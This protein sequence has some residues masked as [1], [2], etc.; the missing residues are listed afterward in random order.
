MKYLLLGLLTF[1]VMYIFDYLQFRE[2]RLKVLAG[3]FGFGGF[4]VAIIQLAKLGHFYE[5]TSSFF[6]LIVAVFFMLLLIW[7]VFIE[8]SFAPTYMKKQ[9]KQLL[10]STGTYALTRHPG[11]VWLF[12]TLLGLS[13]W[14]SSY[15]LLLGVFIFTISNIV[16]VIFQEK[17]FEKMIP[18]YKIYQKEVP[19]LIPNRSS[20]KKLLVALRRRIT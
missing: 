13:L 1:P 6:G 18:G 4:G 12:F 10:V 20:I 11:V 15:Y 17:L 2:S 7:S 5:T 8:V 19:M 9:K 16:Y 14:T 3:V